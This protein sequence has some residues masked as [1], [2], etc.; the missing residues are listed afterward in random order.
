MGL[1][2]PPAVRPST[3]RMPARWLLL[4]LSVSVLLSGLISLRLGSLPIPLPAFWEAL[5]G[6]PRELV[7][8]IIVWQLRVPRVLGGVCVGAAL[9]TSGLLLQSLLRN[10][11][12]GPSVLGVSAGASLGVATVVFA[13]GGMVGASALADAGVFDGG[14]RIG[15]ASLGALAVTAVVLGITLWVRDPVLV[16]IVGLMISH[17]TLA[18]VGLWQYYS[19]PEQLREFLVWSFGS[20]GAIQPR[21]LG[22]LCGLTLAGVLGAW[23][24]ARP[25]N[26]LGFGEA[27]AQQ[28]GVPLMRIR[29]WVILLTSLLTGLVTALAGPIGFV[30][31]AVPHLTRGLYPSSDHWRLVPLNALMGALVLGICD[32]IAQAPGYATLLPL[33]VVTALVGAPVVVWVILRQHNRPTAFSA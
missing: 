4:G 29:L 22:L 14:L 32:A 23:L 7:H 28:L 1:L 18:A 31:I 2:P 26:A 9:A 6:H 25:L 17:L 12:A 27:Y 16:L 30:G 19:A 3:R 13:G 15:A 24:L 21:H 10:P 5:L 20:L 33:N 11:L 8:G